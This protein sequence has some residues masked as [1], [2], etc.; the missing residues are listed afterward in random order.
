MAT[1]FK[2]WIGL[3]TIC[4]ITFFGCYA[5]GFIYLFLEPIIGKIPTTLLFLTGFIAA[6]GGLL[7]SDDDETAAMS[8][9]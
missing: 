7:S 9:W 6:I 2:I 3:I 8:T 5:L 4:V 1:F